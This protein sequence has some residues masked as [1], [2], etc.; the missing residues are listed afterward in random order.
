[1]DYSELSQ[2]LELSVMWRSKLTQSATWLRRLNRGCSISLLFTQTLKP[3]LGNSLIEKWISSVEASLASHLVQQEGKQETKTL[4]TYS[5]TS[6]KELEY[7][8]LP[9]F[10]WKMLQASSAQSLKE[11]NGKTQREHLFCSMSLESW[12]EWAIE[13][14]Q[15]H[16]QREKWEHHTKEKEFLYLLLEMGSQKKVLI[17]SQ[18]LSEQ[19]NL[20]V[21]EQ[22]WKTPLTL[23][24]GREKNLIT[25]KGEVWKGEGRAYRKNGTYKQITLNYQVEVIESHAILQQGALDNIG[26]SHQELML[27]EHC[28]GKLNP[29]WVEMLMGLP[30][31]WTMAS[32]TNPLIIELMSLGYLETELYHKQQKEPLEHYGQNWSTPPASQRGEGLDNYLSRMKSRFK[33]GFKDAFAPTLQVQVEAEYKGVN[34]KDEINSIKQ[35]CWANSI[36]KDKY[37]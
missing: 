8:N 23:D 15:A 7:A 32:C 21:K 28:R 11:I 24:V 3:S 17:E 25:K 5:H 18:N 29:R 19:V 22:N 13:Q 16:S 33:R 12:K 30:I 27:Q 14:R 37:E 35:Q 10:S 2:Q 26:M 31:G 34:I 4:D 9:L 6:P 20:N 1:M 36:D